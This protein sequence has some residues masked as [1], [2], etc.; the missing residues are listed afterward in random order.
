MGFDITMNSM[1]EM[2]PKVDLFSFGG[3][4]KTCIGA[5]K[6]FAKTDAKVGKAA[7]CVTV[8]EED[9]GWY[10]CTDEY[11]VDVN[12]PTHIVLQQ[13][14][15][16]N[17][18]T[19]SKPHVRL[20]VNGKD[21]ASENYDYNFRP[22]PRTNKWHFSYL[23]GCHSTQTTMVDASL[24]NVVI[25]NHGEMMGSVEAWTSEVDVGC[26]T[27]YITLGAIIDPAECQRVCIESF[28]GC[29]DGF[30]Y[31][32]ITAEC[33][34][35]R[36]D[37]GCASDKEAGP[38]Y[39]T[40]VRGDGL[41]INVEGY[42]RR[43]DTFSSNGAGWLSLAYEG[44]TAASCKMHCDK[45]T[46]CEFFVFRRPA[47]KSTVPGSDK[48]CWLY[49]AT[50]FATESLTGKLGF[51]VFVREESNMCL[52]EPQFQDVPAC[53]RNGRFD[54][55]PTARDRTSGAY[56]AVFSAVGQAM[57]ITPQEV[58]RAMGMTY[59]SGEYHVATQHHMR[60]VWYPD[61]VAERCDFEVGEANRFGG[62]VIEKHPVFGMCLVRYPHKKGPEPE[63][64]FDRI[65]CAC[66]DHVVGHAAHLHAALLQ[67]SATS[68]SNDEKY[69]SAEPLVWMTFGP[70]GP[71]S[72]QGSQWEGLETSSSNGAKTK[73]WF[74]TRTT[75]IGAVDFDGIDGEV[76]VTIG[77]ASAA[78]DVAP[79][80]A[81]SNG[82]LTMSAWMNPKELRPA[83]GVQLKDTSG[84]FGA[85]L[86][87][88]AEGRFVFYVQATDGTYRGPTSKTFAREGEWAHVAAV[89][90]EGCMAL[91]VNATLEDK[92][93]DHKGY[94]TADLESSVS[95]ELVIGHYDTTRH[96]SF[97]KGSMADVRV[98]AKALSEDEIR[99]VMKDALP[100]TSSAA[101]VGRAV[102]PTAI[103]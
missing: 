46:G 57:A 5:G 47:T 54:G 18:F 65:Q 32:R 93:C 60:Y 103:L 50:E 73:S 37:V 20:I 40:A 8:V 71:L 79:V 90:E 74:A 11:V 51:D 98:Y 3:D 82:L 81:K 13:S 24:S 91:Y 56:A 12:V 52:P 33:R 86:S 72:T 64:Y 61:T 42:E 21:V 2:L 55:V 27:N 89:F 69:H 96:S 99:E 45:T 6:I 62:I 44:A 14:S 34:F 30:S 25:A 9:G 59:D 53:D 48:N 80:L 75:G 41:D 68:G 95:P 92:V 4:A 28:G 76:K 22:D 70:E 87:R 84:N 49:E 97:F 63:K 31:D 10:M 78:A 77:N 39:Y 67:H 43:S 94:Q 35:P 29:N 1:N 36:D 88:D 101:S 83:A 19:N 100:S 102:I 23:S 38:V 58:C 26:Q 66:A 15:P 17:N 16:E 7:L 85:A